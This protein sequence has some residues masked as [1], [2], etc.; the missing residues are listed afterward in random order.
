MFFRQN[1]I[2]CELVGVSICFFVVFVSFW[3]LLMHLTFLSYIWEN[4]HIHEV[5]KSNLI[6]LVGTN[7]YHRAGE[8]HTYN[9]A[10]V[11]TQ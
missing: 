8:G 11:S 6:L 10:Q 4:A 7:C 9:I 1:N 2:I 5:Q 3:F